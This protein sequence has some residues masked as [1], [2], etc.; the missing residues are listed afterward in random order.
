MGRAAA[1]MGFAELQESTTL[2]APEIENG[3]V[4]WQGPRG[5]FEGIISA[6]SSYFVCVYRQFPFDM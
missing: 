3:F 1:L 4:Y 2:V 6:P 5:L